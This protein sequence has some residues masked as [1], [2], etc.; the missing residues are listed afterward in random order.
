MCWEMPSLVSTRIL[1][2]F[3]AIQRCKKHLPHILLVNLDLSPKVLSIFVLLAN[4][5]IFI[6]FSIYN[7][8]GYKDQSLLLTLIDNVKASFV[9]GVVA[10]EEEC[11][12]VCGAKKRVRN[13][14]AAE[15][16]NHCSRLQ[17][18]TPHFQI[19]MH[20]LCGE[21]QKLQMDP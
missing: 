16:I 12:L 2:G 10:V 18:P 4:S 13:H 9:L 7:D 17:A 20:R 8:K 15:A 21:V 5:Y 3:P 14:G 11:G 6:H 19:V 1:A